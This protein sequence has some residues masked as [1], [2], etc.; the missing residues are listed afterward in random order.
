M[1]RYELCLFNVLVILIIKLFMMI[2]PAFNF[3]INYYLGQSIS[4]R[5][6]VR[7]VLFRIKLFHEMINKVYVEYNI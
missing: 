3:N 4:V 6:T 2:F 1:L 5:H 7:Y